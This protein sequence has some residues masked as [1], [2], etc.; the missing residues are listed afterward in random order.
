MVPLVLSVLMVTLVPLVPLALMVPLVLMIPLNDVSCANFS[1][2]D[3]ASLCS[4]LNRYSQLCS[5]CKPGYAPPVYS[6][7]MDCVKCNHSQ[8]NWLKYIA[9]AFVPVTVF[10]VVIVTFQI[11][12]TSVPIIILVTSSQIVTSSFFARQ[13]FTTYVQY[14][15]KID[16][17]YFTM[18]SYETVFSIWNLDFL[19]ATYTPFCLT[20]SANILHILSLDYITAAYPLVL[21]LLTYILVKLYNRGNAIVTYAWMPFNHCFFRL[22]RY[23]GVSASLVSV[24]ATF[25]LIS[26]IKFLAVSMDLLAPVNVYDIHGNH[27]TFVYLNAS[28]T[29][30]G[31][32]HWPFVYLA[33][34]VLIIFIIIPLILIMLYPFRCFHKLLNCCHLNTQ[35]LH[36]FMDA[37]LGYFK[38]GT[39]G[40]RD[41][42]FFAALYFIARVV[43]FTSVSLIPPTMVPLV[44]SIIG[45]L[46][47]CTITIIRPYKTY[48]DNIINSI[49]I[50]VLLQFVIVSLGTQ[51]APCLYPESI[52]DIY[53]LILAI[54]HIGT[55]LYIIRSFLRRQ[56][57]RVYNAL[58]CCLLKTMQKLLSVVIRVEEVHSE[59]EEL[60]TP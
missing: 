36:I 17:A 33:I 31:E 41:C 34:S 40:T 2:M 56:M 1:S 28:M 44:V 42:R 29:Y 3:E 58:T 13:F 50:M 32:E 8:Y 12:V 60:T 10:Y 49:V 53:H 45:L 11:T 16:S 5:Q 37:Y 4:P 59:Y 15:K 46:F 19:R 54:F 14:S 43:L 48:S 9:V 38:D 22:R 55:L 18:I 47:C 21:I 39:N 52:P 30:C 7:S 27:K 23:F 57:L 35:S 20:P 26:Y 6:Y 25:L 24:F 51:M